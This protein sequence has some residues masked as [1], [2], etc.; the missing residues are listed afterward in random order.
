M[1][2]RVFKLTLMVTFSVTVKCVNSFAQQSILPDKKPEAQTWSDFERPLE[3]NLTLQRQIFLDEMS[4]TNRNYQKSSQ[5]GFIEQ[6]IRNRMDQEAVIQSSYLAE[7]QSLVLMKRGLGK[8]TELV[9]KK[10][11]LADELLF[12]NFQLKKNN[13]AHLTGFS[14]SPDQKKIVI[15]SE[16]DGSI[17][18]FNLN[19]YDL[20]GRKTVPQSKLVASGN[21][22]A[23]VVWIGPAKFYYRDSVKNGQIIDLQISTVPQAVGSYRYFGKYPYNLECGSDNVVK[24]HP[25]SDNPQ[26]TVNL[27]DLYCGGWESVVQANSQEV[28]LIENSGDSLRFV[29]YR[30]TADRANSP[31]VLLFELPQRVFQSVEVVDGLYVIMNSWGADQFINIYDMNGK[32]V[33]QITVPSYASVD[34]VGVARPSQSLR[35]NFG[36]M[37]SSNKVYEYDYIQ[38][39]WTTEPN[40][41]YDL[42]GSNSLVYNEQNFNAVASDGAQIPVRMTYLKSVKLGPDTPMLMKV[43]CGYGEPGPYYPAFDFETR[44][45]F[46]DNGG[47]LVSV[48]CRGGN[49]FGEAWHQQATQLNRKTTF[50]DII[51]VSQYLIDQGWTTGKRI[52]LRGTS[53]GGLATLAAGFLAPQ[54]FGLLL[55]VSPPTDI[56]AKVRLD[57]RFGGQKNEYGDPA[58]S[59]VASY[60]ATYAPLE[61]D[62]DPASVPDIFLLAGLNDSRVN[63]THSFKLTAKLRRIGLLDGQFNIVMV[64]NSGHWLMAENYQDLIAWRAN[65]LLWERVERYFGWTTP[66]K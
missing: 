58:D 35:I 53:A 65:S 66:A 60:M 1:L 61:L 18:D 16:S 51:R 6:A 40:R 26:R 3:N 8:A 32:S 2:S 19:I 39:N 13:S 50:T 45:F 11:G 33:D 31:A 38:H 47:V 9:L 29:R 20:V 55:P 5:R 24:Y 7:G 63:I 54:N 42:T 22:A 27:N 49:Q 28:D 37:I 14:L 44:R 4:K 30:L 41:D 56:I 12:S 25:I 46:L 48:A 64:K 57:A 23:K 62:V 17:D 36:T 59:A 15:F 43:Y 21:G 34:D 52:V 10:S